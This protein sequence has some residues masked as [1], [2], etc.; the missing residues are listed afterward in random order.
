MKLTR[1]D[2]FLAT[3]GAT[4]ASVAGLWV[5]ER[6]ERAAREGRDTF[7]D[8]DVETL[9][10]IADVVYPSEVETTQDVVEAYVEEM[11]A[12]RRRGMTRAI[13]DLNHEVQRVHGRRF[14]AFDPG[15]GDS[16]LRGVGVLRARPLASGTV[17]E[18]IRFYLVNGLLYALYTDPA[19]TGLLG[20]EN[21][22]G[23]P[24]GYESALRGTQWQEESE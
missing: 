3:A 15:P 10:A 21:P 4:A 17:P 19:G 7:G 18:R 14:E 9:R 24:G 2:V 13:D 5:A 11:H 6:D 20:I 8:D 1:R 23:Y 16:I 12:D 22:L